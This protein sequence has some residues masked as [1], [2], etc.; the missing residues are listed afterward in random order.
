MNKKRIKG[1]FA[2]Y[3]RRPSR[4][5]LKES[6]QPEI[7]RMNRPKRRAKQ[8]SG[9]KR[10]KADEQPVAAKKP[11]ASKQ[12]A[13][14]EKKRQTRLKRRQFSKHRSPKGA[15]AHGWR[16]ETLSGFR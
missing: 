8:K 1:G 4:R 16:K 3:S 5:K 14:Q 15:E 12:P 7:K 11:A 10:Q 2:A 9:L 6:K 13:E